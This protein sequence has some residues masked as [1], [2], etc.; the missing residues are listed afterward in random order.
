MGNL[1]RA[2]SFGDDWTASWNCDKCKLAGAY[3]YIQSEDEAIEIG[4]LYFRLHEMQEHGTEA[5]S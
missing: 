2:I 5:K 4:N 1:V 3:Q